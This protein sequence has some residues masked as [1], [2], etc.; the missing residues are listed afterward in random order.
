MAGYTTNLAISLPPCPIPCLCRFYCC[1]PLHSPLFRP[2]ISFPSFPFPP[3]YERTPLSQNRA[4]AVFTTSSQP[5]T[6]GHPRHIVINQQ[7]KFKTWNFIHKTL[8]TC[9]C[10]KTEPHPI[11]LRTNGCINAIILRMLEGPVT[12]LPS[13]PHLLVW[14]CFT[15]FC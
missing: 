11:S 9:V 8:L 4:Y 15:C 3:F 6:R 14:F 10:F 12:C 13:R 2:A 7:S 1:N 5:T